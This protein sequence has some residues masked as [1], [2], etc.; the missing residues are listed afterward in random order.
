MGVGEV[1]QICDLNFVIWSVV[2][3]DF[4]KEFQSLGPATEKHLLPK[5]V[6]VLGIVKD[7]SIECRVKWP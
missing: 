7:E 5:L 2:R 1:K 3:I 6:W 4:G